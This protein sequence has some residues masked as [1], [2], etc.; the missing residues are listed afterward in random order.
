MKIKTIK[1]LI[2]SEKK[3][4]DNLLVTKSTLEEKMIC[5]QKHLQKLKQ[6]LEIELE[7]AT[8]QM[9]YGF[10]S[11][12]FIKNELKKQ[13]EKEL[14]I[15]V[16]DREIHTLLQ[17]IVSKNINKKTYE[18]I[19]EQIITHDNIKEAKAEMELI[20][21]YSLISFNNNEDH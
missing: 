2:L 8:G 11:A 13:R 16:L 6:S 18:H 7:L 9:I 20:D 5:E 3:Q 15:S 17:E 21:A 12:E 10:N 1:K 14:D 4:I 19:L